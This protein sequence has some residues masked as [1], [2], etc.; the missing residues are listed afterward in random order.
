[1]YKSRW[2]RCKNNSIHKAI[3]PSEPT[4][5]VIHAR[6]CRVNVAVCVFSRRVWTRSSDCV[7][8]EFTIRLLIAALSAVVVVWW[9][10][11]CA[12]VM[13]VRGVWAAHRRGR[14]KLNTPP[15]EIYVPQM[16]HTVHIPER[17]WFFALVEW[18]EK[19]TAQR[20]GVC[21][22]AHHTLLRSRYNACT[23]C[24][25]CVWCTRM[26]MPARCARA[27]PKCTRRS[28]RKRTHTHLLHTTRTS[29]ALCF[30]A[31]VITV[32]FHCTCSA[33]HTHT[34]SVPT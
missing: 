23:L 12:R 13:L 26:H 24:N 18:R 34:L 27:C 11:L 4:T 32:W 25:L 21:V 10:C 7:E 1:M 20:L 29:L 30:D 19:Q 16:A 14:W 17:N 8:S 15:G 31:S 5:S 9:W 28:A 6:V 3:H 33:V 2:L 22:R